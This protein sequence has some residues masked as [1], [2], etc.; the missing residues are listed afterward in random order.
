MERIK[1]ILEKELYKN[2]SELEMNIG[3]ISEW[4]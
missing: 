4:Q 3:E 1:E 2:M